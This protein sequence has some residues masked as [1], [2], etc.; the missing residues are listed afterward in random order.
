MRVFTRTIKVIGVSKDELN[1]LQ[2]MVQ[3]AKTNGKA[4][5]QIA[6]NAYLAVDVGDYGYS[7]RNHSRRED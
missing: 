1:A 3:E 6:P 5:R 7:P 4:E 2:D